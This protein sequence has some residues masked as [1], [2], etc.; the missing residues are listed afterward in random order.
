[1]TCYITNS[2]TKVKKFV[3]NRQ[4]RNGTWLTYTNKRK[5]QNCSRTNC[6]V[7]Q[8]TNQPFKR[9]TKK[10]TLTGS[11][12]FAWRASFSRTTKK[13]WWAS[14]IGGRHSMA[15][16]SRRRAVMMRMTMIRNRTTR[17]TTT[18]I[19]RRRKLSRRTSM[20]LACLNFTTHLSQK[21]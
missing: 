5:L 12:T 3:H 1:M 20:P 8:S 21:N 2:S 17:K 14:L 13:T 7:T 11:T 15:R 9:S 6:L 16:R 4:N 18:R 10:T 19:S